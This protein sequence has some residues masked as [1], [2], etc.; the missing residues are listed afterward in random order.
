[1]PVVITEKSRP[2]DPGAVHRLHTRSAA[3]DSEIIPAWSQAASS[4][5]YSG[6]KSHS[7]TS[8]R[9]QI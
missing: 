2:M 6:A 8:T 1:M 5:S 9:N 4:L 3:T 7:H